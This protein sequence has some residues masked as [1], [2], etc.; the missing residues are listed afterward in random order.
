MRN[1]LLSIMT[2]SFVLCGLVD[3]SHADVCHMDKSV[4]SS[5]LA[6][7]QAVDGETD[8]RFPGNEPQNEHACSHHHHYGAF[9]FVGLSTPDVDQLRN[10]VLP[11]IAASS[12][13]AL[14][15]RPPIS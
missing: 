12:F 8:N 15:S 13:A 11:D 9:D 2:F 5:E 6:V 1:I 4:Q 3:A 7:T 10:P 14:L